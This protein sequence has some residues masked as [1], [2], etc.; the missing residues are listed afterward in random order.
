[1]AEGINEVSDNTFESEVAKSDI[2]VLVDFW[3]PWCG[4]CKAIGPV[5]E[6]IAKGY[7]GK[8]KFLKCNVDNNPKTPSNFGIRAIPTLI[9]FK[10][11]QRVDQVVGMVDKSKIQDI[12]NKSL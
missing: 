9:L 10:A 2:P 8:I 1:M 6:E 5:L 12:L 7:A 3:A 4:P 11:G